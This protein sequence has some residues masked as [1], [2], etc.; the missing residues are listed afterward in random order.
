LVSIKL[1][2]GAVGSFSAG[3]FAQKFGRLRTLL[4]NNI[5]FVMGGFLF[6][7]APNPHVMYLARFCVGFGA[8]LGSAIVPVY[9]S[10]LTPI[11]ARG[12]FGAMN[13][14]VIISGVLTAQA[15]G[16]FLATPLLWRYLLAFTIGSLLTI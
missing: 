4:F 7:I 14:L 9:I 13:E 16:L 8:G 6:F 2:G 15:L 12:A 10:E 1:L 5:F 11:K 3:F